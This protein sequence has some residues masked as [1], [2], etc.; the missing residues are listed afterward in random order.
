MLPEFQIQTIGSIYKGI[1][2]SDQY[3]LVDRT[4]D[5]IKEVDVRE[6]LFPRFYRDTNTPGGYFCHNFRYFPDPV[7]PYRAIVIIEHRYDV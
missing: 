4:D 2:G 3:L 7:H 6:H 1:D 5:D